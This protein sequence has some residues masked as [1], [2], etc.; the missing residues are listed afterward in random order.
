MISVCMPYWNRQDKLDGLVAQYA[1]LYPDLSH[2]ISVCD[3]GSPVPA[4]APAHVILTRLP[5]KDRPR[6]PCVPINRAVEASAGDVIALTNPEIRHDGPVLVEML[7]MLRHPMDYI[8]APC[9][10]RGDRS[11][12][13][14][15]AGPETDYTTGGREP[16]PPGGHFHFLVLFTREL[17][18]AAGGFDEDYRDGAACDDNDWLW[19]AYAAGANFKVANGLVWHH[20]NGH[21]RW[22]MP[23]NR[24]RLRSKWPAEKRAALIA[25]RTEQVA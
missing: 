14:W 3:D 18:N 13:M 6:N 4:R 1:T 16:L 19:R 7:A 21:T 15:L 2:E 8:I 5:T 20:R 10:H 23:H 22:G 25:S 9:R 24:Q 12:G 11:N 17:W